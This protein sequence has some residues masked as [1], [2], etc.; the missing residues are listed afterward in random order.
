[1][2]PRTWGWLPGFRNREKG[3]EYFEYIL[4]LLYFLFYLRFYK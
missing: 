4:L 2:S 1:V 3:I